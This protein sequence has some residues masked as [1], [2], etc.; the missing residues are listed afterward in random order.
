MKL[1]ATGEKRREYEK[2]IHLT[3]YFSAGVNAFFQVWNNI[4]AESL[5]ICTPDIL[6]RAFTHLQNASEKLP[7]MYNYK[8]H[9][10]IYIRTKTTNFKN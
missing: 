9:G 8:V 3:G 4:V 10:C 7:F 1:G 5:Y 6:I 2:H